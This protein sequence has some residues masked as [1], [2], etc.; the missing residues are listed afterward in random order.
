LSGVVTSWNG[1]AAKVFGYSAEEMMGQPIARLIPA[2]RQH[3]E[4]EILARIRRGESVRH[5]ETVRQRKDGRLI[6]VSVT[7]SPIKDPAG[8]IIG[9]SK[10]ARDITERRRAERRLREQEEQMSLYAEHSPAAIAMFD[11]DMRYVVASRRW[12]E[13][14]L[15]DAQTIIG[16]GHYDVFPE[17][18][19]RWREIHARCLA[20]GTE[21]CD[22]DAFVR[23]D[24]TTQWLRWEVRPW[25]Q[26]DGEI[27]GIIIFAEDITVRK[28]AERARRESEAIYRTLFDYAP[29]GIVI[30]DLKGYYLDANASMCRMLGRTRE[31]LLHLH[32]S[33]VVA[34]EEIPHIDPALDA[35]HASSNY[36]REWRFQRKDGSIFATDVIGTT[37]PDGNILAMVRDITERREAEEKI[38]RL[39]DELEHRVIERTAQ[40]ETANQELESFS[41]SVS[42]D[43][44]A[45][46]RAVDGFS[47]AVLEDYGPHLPPEGLRYLQTIRQSAQR[48]GA[49]I[50][51]LLAFARLSR[52][53][54]N[55][56]PVD[57]GRLVRETWEELGAS[58]LGRRVEMQ[59]GILPVCTADP[60]L[61]KQVW[62][63]LLSNAVKYTRQRTPAVIEVGCREANGADNFYVR[64]NGAGFDM[65]YADKLFGVFQR[66]HRAEDYEGT[67][68]GLAIVQ[69]IVHRH[70]GRAWAEGAVDRGA[71]FS[72]T[73][74]SEAGP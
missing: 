51:D 74:A 6:D 64:D 58:W 25:H 8:H 16:R 68:V 45:P 36:H 69:R 5:F 7:V 31:E 10:V 73:L 2:E 38:R 4:V 55:K 17:I 46:L 23:P 60:V 71:I 47:Q 33:A 11:R 43:L 59:I 44:R 9:A 30:T 24:G 53:E 14:Y 67:G 63:N 66:L 19:S 62:L 13:I 15:L 18:P 61:L 42:H 20:G 27:G 40:L 21:K 49:L 54:L 26:A 48:M 56:Q 3:E 65:R 70:G 1:G 32:C 12:L 50:D 72:F 41:Y 34:P 52:E 57:T 39:N 35:I 37:L 29:D 22:D 28:Q